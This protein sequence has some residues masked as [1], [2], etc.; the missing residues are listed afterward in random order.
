MGQKMP[1]LRQAQI[2]G[3]HDDF[4]HV[5]LIIGEFTDMAGARIVLKP[6]RQALTAPVDRDDCIAGRVQAPGNGGIFLDIFGAAGKQQD[7]AGGGA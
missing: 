5:A 7:A 3:R 4:D 2:V 1:G 6:L